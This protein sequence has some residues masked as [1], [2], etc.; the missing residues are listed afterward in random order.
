M[1]DN[2]SMVKYSLLDALRGLV[3][4][5]Y[6]KKDKDNAINGFGLELFF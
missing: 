4:M 1:S 5:D 2:I 6:V 3:T